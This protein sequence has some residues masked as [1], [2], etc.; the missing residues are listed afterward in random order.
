MSLINHS[1]FLEHC[2]S[3]IAAPA[4]SEKCSC[5]LLPKT[6]SDRGF[7]WSCSFEELV[8]AADL[9]CHRCSLLQKCISCYDPTILTKDGIIEGTW[10]FWFDLNLEADITKPE[11]IVRLDIF[12]AGCEY[13]N[14]DYLLP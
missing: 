7:D 14:W 4:N 10:D 11:Q 13:H 1:S 12:Y 2:R 6:S 3:R 5:C 8:R 9:G